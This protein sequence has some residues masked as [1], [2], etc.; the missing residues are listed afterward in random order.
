[1]KTVDRNGSSV[2]RILVLLGFFIAIL[3]PQGYAS[4]RSVSCMNATAGRITAVSTVADIDRVL[5]NLP[6]ACNNSTDRTEIEQIRERAATEARAREARATLLDPNATP[7]ARTAAAELFKN[8]GVPLPNSCSGFWEY[9]LNPVSCIGRTFSVV[10]GSALISATA[11]LLAAVGLL[12]NTLVDYT[13]I[14]FGYL[15]NENLQGAI[16]TAWGAFRDIANIVIIGMFVFIAINMILGVKGF[17]DKKK[18]ARVL[19]IAVLLNFSLLFTKIIIDASN[20]TAMQFYK[21]SQLSG[22][23]EGSDQLFDVTAFSK[24]GISGEFIGLLGLDSLKNTTKALSAAAF[25]NEQNQYATANGWTALLHGLVS[26]TLLLVAAFVLLYGCFLVASRAVLLILLMVTSALAFAS[27][28]IPQQYVQGGFAKWW[29]SLLKA[30]FFAP[31][32]MALLWMAL[33]VARAVKPA[34]GSLGSLVADP[35]ATLDLNALFSYVIIIGLLYASFKAAGEF[36]KSISGFNFAQSAIGLAAF[37]PLAGA[38]RVAGFG[39]RNTAGWMGYHYG[40]GL[41]ER[42]EDRVKKGGAA[43]SR[44]ERMRVSSGSWLGTRS[45]DAYN[46]K[47]VQQLAKTLAGSALFQEGEYGKGGYGAAMKRYAEEGLRAAKAAGFK[48]E[49]E[50]R[51]ATGK[52]VDEEH[53]PRH[54][55]LKTAEDTH[56]ANLANAEQTRKPAEDARRATLVRSYGRTD[57]EMAGDKERL[58]QMKRE[59]D[60]ST[61]ASMRAV[62]SRIDTAQMAGQQIDPTDKAEFDRL[63]NAYRQGLD[64]FDDQIA[65]TTRD[66]EAFKQEVKGAGDQAVDAQKQFAKGMLAQVE[67]ERETLKQEKEARIEHA[68]GSISD[69]AVG[70][71][72]AHVRL[73]TL[74]G[75]IGTAKTD[76]ASKRIGS[77][78]KA[79][80]GRELAN[81]LRE[82]AK[83]S[84]VNLAPPS[85][86]SGGAT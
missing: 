24:K 12:F 26:A 27:W 42:V 80:E 37:T 70:A 14:T 73:T 66:M 44:W 23:A 28:L 85:T 83:D 62:Q 34:K 60:S 15:F 9:F 3:L 81:W 11:W 1:M 29:E 55:A 50:V 59:F 10:V 47:P 69:R 7:E 63:Q 40:V 25:G 35:T 78:A 53:T 30:A 19:I 31:I 76:A 82:G 36:S 74:Y 32:L 65:A 67:T 20:F 5:S 38:S 13:I 4:A 22:E 39:L 68:V 17:G 46:Q 84:G 6:S 43:M 72:K 75:L 64:R 41:R 21:M 51:T 33:L 58:E 61:A 52:Q 57:E 71:E 18:V 48:S 77:A 49:G 45:Y 16:G 8:R 56:K 54:E 86:P 2:A 79:V